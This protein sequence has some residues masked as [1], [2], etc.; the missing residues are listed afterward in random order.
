MSE[1]ASEYSTRKYIA[2][3]YQWVE[4]EGGHYRL[5]PIGVHYYANRDRAEDRAFMAVERGQ[6]AGA[7]VLSVEVFTQTGEEG[8]VIHLRRFGE[9][10][11]DEDLLV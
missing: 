2:Q 9:C 6:A 3:I 1:A 8:S 4:I 11:Q 5:E 10:P 7:D